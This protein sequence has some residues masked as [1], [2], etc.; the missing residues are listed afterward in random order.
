[1]ATPRRIR[2]FG[3]LLPFGG[4]LLLLPP[5]L[6]IFDQPQFLAGVPLLP[7]YLFTAWAVGIVLAWLVSRQILKGDADRPEGDG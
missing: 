5:Y 2:D 6:S 4:T 1:M 7:T 3:I